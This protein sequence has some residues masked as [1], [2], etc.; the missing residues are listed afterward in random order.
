LFGVE[1]VRHGP[2]GAIHA[3]D[4][5][6]NLAFLKQNISDAPVVN[7]H[8]ADGEEIDQKPGINH[9]GFIVD[10]VEQSLSRLG[11]FLQRGET[12]QNGRPAEMRF[13]DPWGNKVDLSARGFLGREEKRLPGVRHVVIQAGDPEKTAEFYKSKLDLKEIGRP[14]DGTVRLSDGDI[15]MDLTKKQPIDKQGIQSFGVQVKD[16]SETIGRLKEIGMEIA[17]PKKGET[18]VRV[19]DPEGNIFSISEK[20]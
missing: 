1:K 8:R 7:T 12:P 17:E 19:T 2:T 13:V 14:S 18:E 11:S 10:N 3:I 6:F 20:G 4:G 15:S 9:Y 5:L 16:W